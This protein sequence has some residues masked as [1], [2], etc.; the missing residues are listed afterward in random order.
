MNIFGSHQGVP[1]ALIWS[2]RGWGAG[3]VC[4]PNLQSCCIKTF[5]S[6]QSM[7][8]LI[9]PISKDVHPAGLC[10]LTLPQ[11]QHSHIGLFINLVFLLATAKPMR[12][13]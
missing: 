11:L 1:F 7:S 12:R 13:S 3:A 4:P 6:I 2:P 8:H 10:S 5:V 9:Y